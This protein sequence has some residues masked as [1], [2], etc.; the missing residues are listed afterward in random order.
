[1]ILKGL[2]L[3][4]DIA[5]ECGAKNFYHTGM[6]LNIKDYKDIKIKNK[7]KNSCFKNTLSSV[8]VM[9]SC[10][11]GEN[12]NLCP[13]NSNGKIE[14]IPNLLV[15]DQSTMPSCPTVNP[16]ATA[17]LISMVNTSNYIKRLWIKK[18]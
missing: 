14:G 1:M 8:H 10:S 13:L 5:R 16:Q 11:I 12:K 4:L 6:V 3:I 2:D 9:S 15:V 7:F 18:F 17:S